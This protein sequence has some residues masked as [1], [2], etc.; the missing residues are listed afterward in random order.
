M[1]PLPDGVA[2]PY[3]KRQVVDDVFMP[4]PAQQMAAAGM[5]DELLRWTE[6][7]RRL[8]ESGPPSPERSQGGDP[9]RA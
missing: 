8:R 5:L 6:A 9:I 1:V 2:I 4:S 3:V 7:L